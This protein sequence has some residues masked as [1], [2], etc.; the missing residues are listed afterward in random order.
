MDSE[1]VFWVCEPWLAILSLALD[2]MRLNEGL[3]Q[4]SANRAEEALRSVNEKLVGTGNSSLNQTGLK[5]AK[6][7]PHKI[8]PSTRPIIHII[9]F[10]HQK[11]QRR[12]SLMV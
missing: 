12:H 6:A 11:M 9:S 2:R 3:H 5:V 7:T 1:F 4:R 10:H 8:D